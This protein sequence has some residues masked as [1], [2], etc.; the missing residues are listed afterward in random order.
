MPAIRDVSPSLQRDSG[1]ARPTGVTTQLAGSAGGR[2]EARAFECS[3]PPPH[4]GK[5]LDADALRR[6]AGFSGRP[7]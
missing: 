2:G 3:A 5:L 4:T 1:E 7:K 6:A